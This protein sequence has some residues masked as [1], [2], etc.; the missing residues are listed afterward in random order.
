MDK[1]QS[2][3][4]SPDNEGMSDK[5]LPCPCG[6]GRK[7]KFCCYE[8]QVRLNEISESELLRRAAE[9]PVYRCFI[10]RDWQ[11]DGIAQLLVIRQLPD[12]RYIGGMF[13][14]DVFCLGL[15][16]TFVRTRVEYEELTREWQQFL[17]IEEI[18]FEDARS[19][20]LGA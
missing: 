12:L 5:Y 13:L 18:A 3:I 10:T 7:F 2:W 11:R 16:D 4:P 17:S 15:K 14:V 19:V 20:I 8:K 9:F 6:S 1:D